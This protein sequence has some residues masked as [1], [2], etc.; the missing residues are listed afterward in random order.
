MSEVKII[1]GLCERHGHHREGLVRRIR[2]TPWAVSET[3]CPVCRAEKA[4]RE[5]EEIYG[6]ATNLAAEVDAYWSDVAVVLCDKINERYATRTAI[7]D[8]LV[9][10]RERLARERGEEGER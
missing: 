2:V 6:L 7:V 10:E 9:A 5:L 4:E 1:H 3:D 8:P